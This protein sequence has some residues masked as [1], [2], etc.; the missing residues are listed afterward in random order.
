MWKTVESSL[1]VTR[2]LF[3]LV[4]DDPDEHRPDR[5]KKDE[6]GL[7]AAFQ[8]SIQHQKY[9]RARNRCIDWL[10]GDHHLRQSDRHSDRRRLDRHFDSMVLRLCKETLEVLKSGRYR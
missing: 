6:T 7:D 2:R 1:A 8:V 3:Q 10:P 9:T 4:H 5:R